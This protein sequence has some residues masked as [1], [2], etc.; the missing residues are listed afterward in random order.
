MTSRFVV[1][2]SLLVIVTT[3]RSINNLVSNDILK[4][5]LVFT[6]QLRAIDVLNYLSYVC[7]Q[8]RYGEMLSRYGEMLSRYDEMLSRYGEI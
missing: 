5:L 7:N 3:S 2:T 1:G 4:A 6:V 8:R